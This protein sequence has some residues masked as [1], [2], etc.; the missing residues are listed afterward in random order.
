MLD[1]PKT[2]V[3]VTDEMI[4]QRLK[5]GLR[6]QWWAICPSHFVKDKPVSLFRLGY[7]MVL[8]RKYDGSVACLEDFCPHRGAPLSRGI[9]VDDRIAWS[10]GDGTAATW[11]SPIS[12]DVSQG[13]WVRP[14]R[15]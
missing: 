14:V 2:D 4:E 11:N 3:T 5:V 6:N 8:W 9:A 1:A 10:L 7:R 15:A 12:D 13:T